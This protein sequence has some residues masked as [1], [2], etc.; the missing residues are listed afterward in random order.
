[1]QKSYYDQDADFF[2][3][4]NLKH[5]FEEQVR[6]NSSSICVIDQG[7]KYTYQDVNILA[8]QL[9]NYLKHHNLDRC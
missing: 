7:N 3:T 5:C 6:N 1:M 2:K 8:N 4:T 9:A